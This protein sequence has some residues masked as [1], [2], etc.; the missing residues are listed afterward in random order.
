[1]HEARRGCATSKIRSVHSK[2]LWNSKVI[3]T[4]WLRAEVIHCKVHISPYHENV[5]NAVV[6][7]DKCLDRVIKI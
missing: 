5:I 2:S 3:Y 1:M 4:R 7:L 6:T